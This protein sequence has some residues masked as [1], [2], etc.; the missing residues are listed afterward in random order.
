MKS[1]DDDEAPHLTLSAKAPPLNLETRKRLF[2][3]NKK[4]KM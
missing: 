4:K 2:C 1:E 3:S